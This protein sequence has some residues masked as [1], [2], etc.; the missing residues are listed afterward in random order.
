MKLAI[1]DDIGQVFVATE[2]IEEYNLDKAPAQCSII[3]DI[4]QTLKYIDTDGRVVFGNL[5]I[6][7]ENK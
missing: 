2:D 3:A 1:I 7:E 6:D 5:D 4:R